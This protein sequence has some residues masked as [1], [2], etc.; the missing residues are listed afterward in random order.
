MSQCFAVWR[1]GARVLV[2]ESRNEGYDARTGSTVYLFYEV[3]AS[4]ALTRET[5]DLRSVAAIPGSY[6][7]SRPW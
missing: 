3:P 2:V 5:W 6:P 7:K 4:A 1:K